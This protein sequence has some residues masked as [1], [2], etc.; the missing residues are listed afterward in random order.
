[1]PDNT[2]PTPDVMTVDL[3]T[4][5]L[6]P[7][8][9]PSTEVAE[10]KVVGEETTATEQPSGDSEQN[11]MP[12]NEV[13]PGQEDA[14]K[15]MQARFTKGQQDL[16]GQKRE[17]EQMRQQL[18]SVAGDPRFAQVIADIRA[19]RAAPAQRGEDTQEQFEGVEPEVRAMVD[20]RTKG[21]ASQT[22]VQ[23]LRAQ[24]ERKDFVAS[25]PDWTDHRTGISREFDL[26]GQGITM[27]Q[28]YK[29]A[30]YSVM[31]KEVTR[32]NAQLQALQGERRKTLPTEIGK[33]VQGGTTRK[34]PETVA[35]AAAIALAE[36]QE[37]GY[38]FK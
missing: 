7:A 25:R 12:T 5:D 20:H 17:V 2:D 16:A 38:K 37:A 4:G 8:T 27:D 9:E 33:P 23:Q 34:A 18:E 35:E 30:K 6:T 36:L 29:A 28:A 14:Y 15:S 1:M 22:E 10:D 24:I 21:L 11:F 13:V 19:G 26:A 32:L 31:E 3:D